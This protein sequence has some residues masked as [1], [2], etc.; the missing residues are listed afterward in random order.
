MG[1]LSLPD[2]P[3][4]ADTAGPLWLDGYSVYNGLNDKIS[5]G[6][7]N[8]TEN[9]LK[10]VHVDGLQISVFKPAEAFGNAKRRVR[11]C[12]SLGGSR[13]C[14]WITDPAYEKKYLAKLDGTY[15]V[16]ECFL[17]VSL[18]EPFSGAVYKLIASIIEKWYR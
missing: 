2:L 10:L 12:F 9:T 11:G 3:V 16:G 18:G 1:R 5:L 17:T 4:L 15:S 13:Y 6:F 7:V 8:S 14:L